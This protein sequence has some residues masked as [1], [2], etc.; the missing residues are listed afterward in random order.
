[1]V[2]FKNRYILAD[3]S[4]MPDAAQTTDRSFLKVV[5][6][7]CEEMLGELFL[8]KVT[9]SLQIKYMQLGKVLI[10]VPRD[11]CTNLIACLFMLK[12]L[13]IVKTSGTIRGIQ[14]K[15]YEMARKE[16]R[17][18]LSKGEQDLIERIDYS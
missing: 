14:Q 10:R 12:G 7:A 2:R 18:E 4:Q 16:L 8:A 9:F 15:L 3:Y 17:R 1:M 6:Q 11:H 5:K 13:K